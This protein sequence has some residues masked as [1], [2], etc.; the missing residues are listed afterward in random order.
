MLPVTLTVVPVCVVAFTL[1]PPST[2][3]PVMLPVALINPPV[4]ILPPVALPV[5]VRLPNVPTDVILVCAAV[6]SVPTILV[7]LRLPPVILPVAE[8][9]PAVLILAPVTLPVALEYPIML[10]PLGLMLPTLTLPTTINTLAPVLVMDMEVVPLAIV[11]TDTLAAAVTLL[12][13][14]PSPTKYAL[15]TIFP[16]PLINPEPNKMLPPVILPVALN[17][18]PVRAVAATLP[19]VML[20]VTLTVVPV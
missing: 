13:Y 4:K 2:L 9:T 8:T 1:A 12:R 17:V 6:V 11:V 18:V 10:Y 19:P 16:A 14:P 20:P 5:T 15:V 7:P 3:P